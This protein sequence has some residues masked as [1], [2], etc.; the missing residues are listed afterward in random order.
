MGRIRE[1]TVLRVDTFTY[2]MVDVGEAIE[3]KGKSRRIV[4]QIIAC[5]T[6]VGAN[7]AEADE[8]MSR[9]DLAK[10]LGVVL[11]ELNESR[12][13]LRFLS[14]RAWIT[15]ARLA[16]LQTEA[17]ELKRMFGAMISRTRKATN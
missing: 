1:E 3:R 7:L 15:P 12:Y 17:T 9:A 6:S 10:T 14:A 11:K 8:A 13:W 4:D 16:A 2:R 5:G